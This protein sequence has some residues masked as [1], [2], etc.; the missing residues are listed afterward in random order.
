M[1]GVMTECMGSLGDI[2]TF[3]HSLSYT[4]QESLRRECAEGQ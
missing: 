4:I 3:S 2:A 1:L